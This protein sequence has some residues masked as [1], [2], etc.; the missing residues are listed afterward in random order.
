LVEELP[1]LVVAD[2]KGG[3]GDLQRGR[4]ALVEEIT[5]GLYRVGIWTF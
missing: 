5:D 2:G 4:G 3:K 1:V